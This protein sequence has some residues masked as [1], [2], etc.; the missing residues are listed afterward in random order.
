MCQQL[1]Q[2]P[3]RHKRHCLLT[4]SSASAVFLC[5]VNDN[6]CKLLNIFKQ[7]CD[8]IYSNDVSRRSS[9]HRWTGWCRNTF[10]SLYLFYKQIF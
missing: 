2:V 10:G 8:S 9:A 6:R 1:L 7:H 5:L 3:E 4:E